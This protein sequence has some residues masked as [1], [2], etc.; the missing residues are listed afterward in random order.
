MINRD[1]L[2][3]QPEDGERPGLVRA[4]RAS[5]IIRLSIMIIDSRAPRINRGLDEISARFATDE[6]GQYE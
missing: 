5:F 6:R 3:A 2:F 1:L 4:P